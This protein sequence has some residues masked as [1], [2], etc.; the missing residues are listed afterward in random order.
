[1]RDDQKAQRFSIDLTVEVYA[2]DYTTAASEVE[3]RLRTGKNGLFY[4][5]PIEDA[6]FMLAIRKMSLGPVKK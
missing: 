5:E 4:N 3:R 2:H 1:M 6:N